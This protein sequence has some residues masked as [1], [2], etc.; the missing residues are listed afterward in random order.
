MAKKAL[1]FVF[2]FLICS[3]VF[4]HT[5]A[6]TIYEEGNYR[7][8][9]SNGIPD[10]EPGQF[11]NSGNP[12]AISE[13]THRFRVP[14][15]PRSTGQAKAFGHNLFGV[16][17]NGVPF[18]P[19]TVEYWNNEQGSGWNYDAMSGKIN[20]G[21]DHSHAHVQPGGMYHYHGIPTDM[22]KSISA[23]QLIGYAADGFPIYYDTQFKTSYRLKQGTR[24]S[25]QGGSYDGTFVEDYAYHEGGG[26][27]DECNGRGYAG[28]YRYY[29]TD[30]FPFVPRCL[31]GEP[32]PSFNKK[33]RRGGPG[34]DQD[35]RRTM[36]S[37]PPP[38]GMP[39]QEALDACEQSHRADACHFRAP[40]GIVSGSCEEIQGLLACVPS[41]R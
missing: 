13:Q 26:D 10:H 3:K 19:E 21:L 31:K 28:D 35:T 11:P 9:E 22:L 1:S 24:P 36:G 40:H 34:S 2:I 16:A 38:L 33:A 25:G 27:L 30:E 8:I 15:H 6:V 41:H 23:S 4:A 32:D 14:I 18:D 7:Y 39:P 37:H 29:L 17:L 20:L 5:N 12:N